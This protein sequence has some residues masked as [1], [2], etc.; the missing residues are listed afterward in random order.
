[1]FN[2]KSVSDGSRFQLRHILE[3]SNIS[4]IVPL[5]LPGGSS[6]IGARG[7][8]CCASQYLFGLCF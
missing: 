2:V 6:C 3:T 8:G 7:G 4:G 1:M 5:N